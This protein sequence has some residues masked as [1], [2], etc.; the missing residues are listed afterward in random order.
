MQA[1]IE[2]YRLQDHGATSPGVYATT[3]KPHSCLMLYSFSFVSC[4]VSRFLL[5]QNDMVSCPCAMYFLKMYDVLPVCNV[6]LLKSYHVLSL[7]SVIL[8]Q[9]QFVL[10]N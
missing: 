3:M 7:R 1:A 8:L 4:R 9:G 5:C 2:R 10:S 6:V